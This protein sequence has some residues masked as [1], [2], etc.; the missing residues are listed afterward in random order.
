MA[1]PILGIPDLVTLQKEKVDTVNQ[2]RD[3]LEAAGQDVLDLSF[4]ADKTLTA[5]EFNQNQVI[6]CTDSA[7]PPT[8][9]V[10]LYV[11]ANKR[12]FTVKNDITDDLTV[13]VVGDVGSAVILADGGGLVTLYSDGTNVESSGGGSG[14]VVRNVTVESLFRGAHVRK[15]V[16]QGP[17]DPDPA[18]TLTFNTVDL[19]TASIFNDTNDSLVVPSGAIK[20]RIKAAISLNSSDASDDILFSLEKDSATF[21]GVPISRHAAS[22]SN[23]LSTQIDTGVIEVTAGEEFTATIL[24]VGETSITVTAAGTWLEMEIIETDEDVF[25]PEEIHFFQHGAPATSDDLFVK[26]F[27][28][29]TTI[30]DALAGTEA[31]AIGGANGGSVVYDVGRGIAGTVTKIGDIT[32]ADTTGADAAH[33]ALSTVASQPYVFEVGEYLVI[34]SPADV[35]SMADISFDIAGFRS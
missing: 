8:G 16:N 28:R 17:F 9:G 11:P 32:F 3:L 14:G 35:Q 34:T 22:S 18:V 15:S 4:D 7:P 29:R 26:V 23:V 33:S 10:T 21:T 31:R 1:S 19:D 2:Q 25:P 24:A 30:N 20:V 13:R 12:D 6:R 27:N 5:A